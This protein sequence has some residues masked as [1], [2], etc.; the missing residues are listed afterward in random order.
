MAADSGVEIGG[1]GSVQWVVRVANARKGSVRSTPQ[2]AGYLQS[3]IDETPFDKPF[4]I[5]VK[6]PRSNGGALA[7]ALRA[8]AEDA[9][10][11]AEDP[12]YVVTFPLVIEPDNVDQISVRWESTPP[13][14]GKPGDPLG[15]LIDRVK[16]VVR[17]VAG[18]KGAAPKGAVKK[19]GKKPVVTKATARKA[20]AKKAKAGKK[21]K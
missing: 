14:P 18:K 11:H 21:K 8:A 9:A 4:T 10:K 2:G 19:P 17:K 12:G 13:A 6:V 16:K 15:S 20:P 7:E 3:G 1:D 5:G